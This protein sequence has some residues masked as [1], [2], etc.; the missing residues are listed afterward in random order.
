MDF[1]GDLKSLED[2]FKTKFKELSDALVEFQ[3]AKLSPVSEE[4][5]AQIKHW[6]AQI[7][8]ITADISQLASNIAPYYE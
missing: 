1:N 7:K 5:N 2:Q 6:A 3:A 4:R 8:E